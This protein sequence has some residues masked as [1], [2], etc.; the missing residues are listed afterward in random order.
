MWNVHVHVFLS[1][2]FLSY[3]FAERWGNLLIVWC[4]VSCTRTYLF[5][6]AGQSIS[7][8]AKGEFSVCRALYA[9]F[10]NGSEREKEGKKGRES[11]EYN[12]TWIYHN[13]ALNS[14]YYSLRSFLLYSSLIR[15]ALS[16]QGKLH[17]K[18]TYDRTSDMYAKY[19]RVAKALICQPEID[20]SKQNFWGN[21]MLRNMLW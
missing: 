15:N 19:I 6:D 2:F 17:S 21:K 10:C 18:H 13:I 11:R 7:H 8:S 5:G 20:I 16:L 12:R 9:Q 4:I 1:I 14:R 3:L